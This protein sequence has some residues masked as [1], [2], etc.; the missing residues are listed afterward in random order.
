MP[1]PYPSWANVH[2]GLGSCRSNECDNSRT[3][4]SVLEA[5]RNGT[6]EIEVDTIH[7]ALMEE[8]ED[9]AQELKTE[10]PAV[11]WSG[12]FS[13]RKIAG[14]IAH[15]GLLCIDLDDCD[16]FGKVDDLRKSIIADPTTAAVFRSPRGLG[17]K[18][19]LLAK[20]APTND[21]EHKQLF[22]IVS[23]RY[24][25]LHRLPIDQSGKDVSR[26]CF[27]SHDPE[28]FVRDSPEAI[29]WKTTVNVPIA[30]QKVVEAQCEHTSPGD[31]Y[32]ARGDVMDLLKRHDW[33][34]LQG[35][36]YWTRPGKTHG[37]SA[38]LNIIPDRFWCFTSSTIFE[39]NKLY[40][41]WHV[42]A[43]L[44]HGG[45][46]HAAARSLAAAGFGD[47]RE[48]S[49]ESG[50]VGTQATHDEESGVVGTQ[51]VTSWRTM[52]DGKPSLPPITT[53]TDEDATP[54]PTPP[55]IIRSVLYKGAKMMIAGPAKARKTF[56]L[57]DLAMS[58]QAGEPWLGCDTVQS[59]VLYLNFELQAFD[60]R[61]RRLAISAAKFDR[62]SPDVAFWHLRGALSR[63]GV[64]PRNTYASII[65][66]I[67]EFSREHEIGLIIVDPI[68]KLM[69]MSGEEN[70]A[71]DVGRLLNE[72]DML[73]V[74]TGAA[75]AFCHHFAKGNASQKD[76]IDRASGSGVYARDPDAL[77][78]LTPHDEQDCMTCDMTLRNFRSPDPFALRWRFPT[79]EVADDIDP[80]DLK[81]C[82]KDEEGQPRV[83]SYDREKQRL[84]KFRAYIADHCG[85]QL[86]QTNADDVAKYCDKSLATIWKWWGTI[87]KHV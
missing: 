38:S 75:V 55:E 71:E 2:V 33:K 68:Y 24:L 69:Q 66:G 61:N 81:G 23:R 79:W 59:N 14:L 41:P 7:Q 65:D 74:E 5:I 70:K 83:S 22:E 54:P 32:D 18:V 67:S 47:K 8:N 52:E 48:P 56:A 78:I 26:L 72:L 51:A 37:I 57:M 3:A 45:D 73:T 10:L 53:A 4:A 82:K 17:L 15:T 77:V 34:P 39:Q 58:V 60:S 29:D 50:V 46:F 40:R 12:T 31:D 25:N 20:N 86:T 76:S 13:T 19:L 1:T 84:E 42:Y 64:N 43:I 11:T 44:E 49:H 16:E 30:T 80:N 63:R 9:K 6:Y 27:V 28:L 35:G 85:G 36:K 87:G 21:A 62:N